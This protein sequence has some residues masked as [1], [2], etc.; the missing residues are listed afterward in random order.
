MQ[1]QEA[2]ILAGVKVPIHGVA[3]LGDGVRHEA[4]LRPLAVH[5]LHQRQARGP[6]DVIGPRLDH[7]PGAGR[8]AS[9]RCRCR[10]L[11]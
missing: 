4:V 2:I 10:H 8:S 5:R 9:V 11:A 6:G 3:G 7:H 1:V